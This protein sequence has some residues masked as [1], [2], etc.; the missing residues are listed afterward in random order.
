[1]IARPT[2]RIAYRMGMTCAVVIA[3]LLAAAI[4]TGH[5]PGHIGPKFAPGSDIPI[6]ARIRASSMA[7]VNGCEI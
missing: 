5:F 6:C 3:V 7:R 1:M 4:A 2:S